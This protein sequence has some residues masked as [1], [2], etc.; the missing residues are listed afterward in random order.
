MLIKNLHIAIKQVHFQLCF[1]H[2]KGQ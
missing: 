2:P 1:K